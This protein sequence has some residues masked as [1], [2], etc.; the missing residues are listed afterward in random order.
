[1]STPVLFAHREY[2]IQALAAD[3]V[4]L[5]PDNF[6]D[7]GCGEGYLL[8]LLDAGGIVNEGIERNP[9]RVAVAKE[10]GRAVREGL[11]HE[12]P[13]PDDAF[14]T[15]LI[16]H[17]LHH[18]DDPGRTVA[19]AQR[20][21]RSRVFLAEPTA[22]PSI[23]SQVGMTRLDVFLSDLAARGGHIHHPFL[24]AG[25]LI[26][27]SSSEPKCVDIRVYGR[28]SR[29][30]ADELRAMIDEDAYGLELTEEDVS[31]REALIHEAELGG[32][33]YN[34]SLTVCLST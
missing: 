6:L 22:E 18:L 19:E 10:K 29:A 21:A 23:P 5:R 32:I 2:L 1:M 11:A 26:A 25:E 4:A 27:L 33:S 9:R 8:S 7:V 31:K 3:L 28:L 24:T 15:V 34:G 14:D 30:T 17:V 16:R 20:V 13:F 12:L